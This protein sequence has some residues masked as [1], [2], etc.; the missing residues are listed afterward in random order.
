MVSKGKA[1]DRVEALS[2]GN[3]LIQADLMH[4]VSDNAGFS[5]DKSWFRFRADDDHYDGMSFYGQAKSEHCLKAGPVQHKKGWGWD[6]RA[7]VVLS[8]PAQFM[9]Y[10]SVYAAKPSKVISLKQAALDLSECEDCKKDFH[11]FTLSGGDSQ[12]RH[13]YC[14][15]ASKD[16]QAF[17]EALTSLGVTLQ[18]EDLHSS[19]NSLFEFNAARPD[20]T[21]VPFSDFAGQVCLAVNVASY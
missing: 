6:S 12:M 16:Q 2:F 10:D 21:V 13:V 1:L 20:G 17:M 9:Q 3:Q 8:E 19:A 15:S 18:R 7:A 14:T 4:H 5:D 11:C